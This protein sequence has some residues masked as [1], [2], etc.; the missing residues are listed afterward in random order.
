MWSYIPFTKARRQRMFLKGIQKQLG[1][2]D[3]LLQVEFTD[4]SESFVPGE[5]KHEI[6]AWVTPNDSRFFSKGANDDVQYLLGTPIVH[7]HAMEAGVVSKEATYFA[8]CE[9]EHR[10]CDADGKALEVVETDEGGEPI[11]VRYADNGQ[12]AVAADGG[13]VDLHYRYDGRV[14]DRSKAGEYDPYPVRRTDA[15][16]A[17]EL[18]EAANTV[19]QNL[20]KRDL[21]LIGVGVAIPTILWVLNWLMGAIAGGGED[22]AGSIVFIVTHIGMLAGWF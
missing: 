1:K 17:I 21:M 4:G 22:G 9:D 20:T 16:V 18:G 3:A 14:I 8:H 10:Y 19:S 11:E 15:D 6:S 13:M 2:Y 7:V 5:Y 12:K